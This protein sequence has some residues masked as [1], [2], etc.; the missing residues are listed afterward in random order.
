M[1]VRSNSQQRWHGNSIKHRGISCVTYANKNRFST[2]HILRGE[3]ERER[4]R[5]RQHALQVGLLARNERKLTRTYHRTLTMENTIYPSN[6]PP[7]RRLSAR[8]MVTDT[9]EP[10]RGEKLWV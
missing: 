2:Q 5:D 9:P 3:R 1:N 6:M 4:E 8:P 7:C 10:E